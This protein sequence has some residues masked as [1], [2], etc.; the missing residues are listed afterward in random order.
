MAYVS[1]LRF[2][3][4]AYAITSLLPAPTVPPNRAGNADTVGIPNRA[5]LELSAVERNDDR[6]D[7]VYGQTTISDPPPPPG[8]KEADGFDVATHMAHPRAKEAPVV[9]DVPVAMVDA[10]CYVLSLLPLDEV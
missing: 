3:L 9:P 7:P 6:I 10:F 5:L 2:A 8:V 4:R 1:A